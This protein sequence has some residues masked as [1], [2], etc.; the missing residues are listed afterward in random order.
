MGVVRRAM[1][2]GYKKACRQIFGDF[3]PVSICVGK[4]AKKSNFSLMFFTV[5]CGKGLKKWE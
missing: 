5:F 1:I 3:R 4:P 2:V